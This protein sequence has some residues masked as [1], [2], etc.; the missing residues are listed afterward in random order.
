MGIGS[1]SAILACPIAN[2]RQSK[3]VS[4]TLFTPFAHVC[5]IT[6]RSNSRISL[7]CIV[8]LL[9]QYHFHIAMT[10]PFPPLNGTTSG[11][12]TNPSDSIRQR[13]RK[14][15]ALGGD[16][17]G[18]VDVPSFATARK[19]TPPLNSPANFDMSVRPNTHPHLHPR[20][21]PQPLTII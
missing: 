20:A 12:S 5:Y 11:D 10:E 17:P 18:D 19:G 16:I 15:S 8:V 7:L 4:R 3:G 2:C 1:S 14:S 6:N 9:L 13:R 21:S